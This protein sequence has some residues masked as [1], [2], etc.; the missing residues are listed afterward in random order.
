MLAVD[1]TFV[2]TWR[3]AVTQPLDKQPHPVPVPGGAVAE[4]PTPPGPSGDSPA[5]GHRDGR[6]IRPAG[7]RKAR[8][9]TRASS[10][11]PRAPVGPVDP[12]ET[13]P[14]FRLDPRAVAGVVGLG[15]EVALLRAAIR[16]LAAKKSAA[17]HVKTLAELR[18]QV[19]ALCTALK[20][21]HALDGR[22]DDLSADLAR[23]LE[24]LGDELGVPR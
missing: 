16:R 11:G 22:G 19:E 5:P 21:Q 13:T 6:E 20:T 14:P 8:R 10:V 3:W 17:P 23:S 9:G 15:H 12:G 4:L 1:R 2:L 18:H 7:V 24:A